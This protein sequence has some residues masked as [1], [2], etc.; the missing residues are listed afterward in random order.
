[1]TITAKVILDSVSPEGIR[2]T[3]I[4]CRYPRFI[5]AEVNTHRAFSR[6]SR[7]SRA[8]PVK[9]IIQEVMDDPAMPVMWGSNRPGMQAGDELTH[10]NK[11]IAESIWLEA[12]DEAVAKAE[13]LAAYGAHKQI[14]NRIL[15]PF[16]HAE[17]VITATEWANFFTLRCHEDADPTM[18]ALAEAMEEAY[19]SNSPVRI[20]HRTWHLPYIGHYNIGHKGTFGDSC[21]TLIKCSVARCARVSYALH[22]GTAAN[23][24]AD[25]ALYD[26]LANAS[27]PHASPLEHQATPAR[28]T[29]G[30]EW[31]GNL[32]GWRQYRKV[33]GL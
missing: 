20:D 26:R 32:K 19:F 11:L 16:A 31:C 7:S 1:M 6:S 18:C 8:V 9:R 29:D 33:I 22:D 2:L 13:S 25:L 30:P 10:G 21:D 12:R 17:T 15:E 28:M 3:T 23:M 14:V 4:Q 24:E 27:P 5:L